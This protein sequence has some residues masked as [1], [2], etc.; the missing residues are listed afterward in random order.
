MAEARVVKS[1][2]VRL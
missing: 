1:N 2:F